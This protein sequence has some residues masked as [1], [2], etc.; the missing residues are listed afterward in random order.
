MRRVVPRDPAAVRAVRV[1]AHAKLNLGLVVGP[2]RADGF[3]EIATVFQS[4]CLADTLEI[5]PRRAGF[6]LAVRAERAWISGRGVRDTVPS[7]AGN[8]VMRAARLMA[9]EA[10]FRGGASMRLTKRIP[11]GAGMGGG[12]ADA[13]AALVG[14]ARLQGLR[15]GHREKM[16]L[17]A[18]LGSDVPFACMG[19]TALGLGRGERLR[20]L[21]LA[22]PLRA[23]VAMPRWKVSTALG[24]RR[25]DRGKYALTVWRAKLRSA[26]SLGRDEVTAM[27]CLRLGNDFE[28]AL[29]ARRRDFLS[30]VKRLRRAGL[31][32]PRLTGSG[33]AT[34]GILRTGET[35]ESVVGRFDGSER[36]YSVDSVRSS[37][38]IAVVL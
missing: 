7:G 9:R 33:S 37:L 6:R 12:S 19:G 28:K 35:V 29:G 38:R 8:L 24:Y 23:V 11:V 5:R 17:A 4:V 20:R 26:Q 25:L 14:L 34:F 30:L 36:L 13:A 16:R 32:L 31:R 21:R 22:R 10:G 3:H 27:K 2:R 15:L 18:Q 1:E